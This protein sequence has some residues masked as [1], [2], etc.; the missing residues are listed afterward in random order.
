VD[1]IDGTT[2]YAAGRE[3][4]AM[5][6]ALVRDGRTVAACILDP[7]SGVAATAEL[8]SGAYLGGSLTI[9]PRQS[10]PAA[11]L[12]GMSTPRYTPAARRQRRDRQIHADRRRS[13]RRPHVRRLRVPRDR[14]R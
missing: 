5:M 4:F 13:P 7:V 10:R 2:N 6:V 8:G 3:P 1:P 12:R 9:A 11:Q 14:A